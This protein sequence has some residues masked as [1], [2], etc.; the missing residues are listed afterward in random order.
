MFAGCRWVLQSVENRVKKR[1]TGRDQH[2]SDMD[3]AI[4]VYF[5]ENNDLIGGTVKKA[6]CSTVCDRCEFG[7]CQAHLEEVC[8]KAYFEALLDY[9]GGRRSIMGCCTVCHHEFCKYGLLGD[10]NQNLDT[11][12]DG[13]HGRT[14]LAFCCL[15]EFQDP[16]DRGMEYI[17][18]EAKCCGN[19][20]MFC[21]T[22]CMDL[23]CPQ[24]D[25]CGERRHPAVKTG[26][27]CLECQ[28]ERDNLN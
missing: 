18:N 11:C 23:H 14:P 4:C 10:D 1:M 2:T 5:D 16:N 21:S 19:G 6:Q 13:P 26:T 20:V 24:C 12:M 7:L 17:C 28:A 9:G 27:V 8:S 25:D 22:E 15:L 3:C